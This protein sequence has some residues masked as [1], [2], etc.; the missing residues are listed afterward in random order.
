MKFLLDEMVP[1]EVAEGLRAQGHDAVVVVERDELRGIPDVELFARARS[2]GRAFVTYNRDDF[3]NIGREC[4]ARGTSHH[5][6]AIISPRRFPEGRSIG[7]LVRAL[8]K[9]ARTG[10]P[11]PNFLIWLQ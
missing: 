8:D 2:E 11:Y 9:L 10:D 4:A 3:I 5:G 7:R 1:P 6:I